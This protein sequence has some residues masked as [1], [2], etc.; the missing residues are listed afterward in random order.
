VITILEGVTRFRKLESGGRV[1]VQSNGCRGLELRKKALPKTVASHP[2][3]RKQRPPAARRARRS[4]DDILNRIV[5]AATEEFKRSG[6]TG[7]T[8]AA[9]ARNADVT[10]AQLFRYFGSKANL[11]RETIFKPIDRHFLNFINHHPPQPN[12]GMSTR[13]MTVLY[14][15]ELQRFISEHSEM[16]ISLLV[17][18]TYESGDPQGVSG[19]N[20]L[21]AYFDHGAAMMRARIKG[22]PR[23]NPEILVRVTFVTVLATIM[24]KSWIFPPDLASEPEITAAINDFVMDGISANSRK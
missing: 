24:F 15:T 22:K 19:I 3:R 4:T 2:P 9:I 14:T 16:L 1:A 18:Q 7:T 23:V 21:R 12:Q 10:E 8:T 13:A 20:S 5:Q 6:Y 17:A 11:F